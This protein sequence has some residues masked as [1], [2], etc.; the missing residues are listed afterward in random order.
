M[1]KEAK[2]ELHAPAQDYWGADLCTFDGAV[3]LAASKGIA[4]RVLD[5]PRRDGLNEFEFTNSDKAVVFDVE[6]EDVYAV[7]D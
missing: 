6:T 7:E 3:K 2:F 5:S 1:S 4:L